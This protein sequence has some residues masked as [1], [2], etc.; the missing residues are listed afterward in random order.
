[1]RACKRGQPGNKAAQ[2]NI[3]VTFSMEQIL[4]QTHSTIRDGALADDL[5][6][7]APSI[8]KFIGSSLR[9]AYFLLEGQHIP[10]G[11][12]GRTWIAS[13]TTLRAHYARLT[14]PKA[15]AT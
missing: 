14:G 8:A 5:L 9:H 1:M 15:G 3:N 13:K 12:Q 6:R 10:A 2:A 4:E 11:Q 7:G